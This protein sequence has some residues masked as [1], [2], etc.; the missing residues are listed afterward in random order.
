MQ[1]KHFFK[2][3]YTVFKGKENN[4]EILLA[5]DHGKL[6]LP[7]LAGHGHADTLSIWLSIDG[8]P[9]FVDAGTY[10]YNAKKEWREYFKSTIAH[11]TLSINGESSSVMSG[12]FNWS[13]QA[14][15]KVLSYN[16]EPDNWYI[17]AEHNGYVERF[18]V[19]HKR[20]IEM[21][22]EG[23]SIK[24]FVT[25]TKNNAEI[26]FMLHPDLDIKQEEDIYIITKDD[27]EF[28]RIKGNANTKLQ[29]KILQGEENPIRAWYSP[30]FN[31]KTPTKQ[32]VFYGDNE[33]KTILK[34][35][36]HNS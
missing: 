6:G 25:S 20:K 5:F 35:K 32:I 16:D 18:G 11:N 17:E 19:I 27:K 2:G 24:D 12:S 10:T 33:Y 26:G 23:I 7:P 30:E 13:E 21:G 1:I 28:L 29:S 14:E 31:K 4:K 22:E 3:G 9:I 8:Q 36:T 15:C 34:L